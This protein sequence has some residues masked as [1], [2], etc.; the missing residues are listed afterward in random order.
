MR[1]VIANAQYRLGRTEEA[2]E[3]WEAARAANP[4]LVTFRIPLIDHYESIGRHDAAAVIAR[5]I[6]AVNPTLTAE[7]AANHGFAAR[8]PD[9]IPSLIAKLRRAG[10]P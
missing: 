3:L 2:V 7:A 6:L 10:L 8:S 5:E 9:A 1:G 4:D